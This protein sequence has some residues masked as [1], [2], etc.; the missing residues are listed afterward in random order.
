MLQCIK[1]IRGRQERGKT[2]EVDLQNW[3]D[4]LSQEGN[5]FILYLEWKSKTGQMEHIDSP[6]AQHAKK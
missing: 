2:T 1:K 4:L 3:D 5:R 6:I